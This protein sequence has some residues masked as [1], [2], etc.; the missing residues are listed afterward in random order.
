MYP[1][2]DDEC[3]MDFQK[4]IDVCPLSKVLLDPEKEKIRYI[5]VASLPDDQKQISRLATVRAYEGNRKGVGAR[6]RDF[7]KSAGTS[8][9][10]K[11]YTH[12]K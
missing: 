6:D 5:R 7:K 1:L 11:I 8:G 2:I 9:V 3:F 4:K 12:H 10:I